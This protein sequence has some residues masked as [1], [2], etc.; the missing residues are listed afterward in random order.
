[1]KK[2][3]GRTKV[4]NN[5]T[6]GKKNGEHGETKPSARFMRENRS[7]RIQK[8]GLGVLTRAAQDAKR[9]KQ[10]PKNESSTLSGRGS[11]RTEPLAQ[12]SGEETCVRGNIN[13]IAGKMWGGDLGGTEVRFLG[14]N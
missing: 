11:C 13:E 8:S 1:V 2:N 5:K 4:Q 7:L 12:G 14:W 10:L 6:F 9:K 3:T